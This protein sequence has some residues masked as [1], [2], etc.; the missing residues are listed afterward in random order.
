MR[1]LLARLDLVTPEQEREAK[2]C[3]AENVSPEEARE[4]LGRFAEPM[5]RH[6]SEDER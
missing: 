4:R 5:M 2:R 3:V 6:F 1:V